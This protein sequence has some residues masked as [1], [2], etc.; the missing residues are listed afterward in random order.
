LRNGP[1]CCGFTV[2]KSSFHRERRG[3]EGLKSHSYRKYIE[4][5]ALCL[6]AIAILWWF[7]RSLNWKEVRYWLGTTNPYL[8]VVAVA[9]ISSAYLVRA[10]RWRVLLRPTGPARLSALFTATTVGFAAVFLLG[11][12]G[13]VVRPVVLPVQ[14]PNV[15][16][17]SSF[18]TIFVERIYDLMAVILMFAFNLLWLKP[19]ST[20]QND[21]PRLRMAGIILLGV[22]FLGVA[23][24]AVFR[25]KSTL[26]IGWIERLFA[27]WQFIPKRVALFVI[28]ILD[29]LSKS[30]RVLVD[31][32]ELV[33]T[34]G[35]TA[36]LWFSVAV[37]NL[38]VI[39]AFGVEFGPVE[40]VFVL[41]WSLVGSLVPTPGGAAG[42]F[43]AATAAALILLGVG[44]EKAAAMSIV[45]HLV[46]FGPALLFGLFYL[47]RGD[48]N[49]SRLR[50]LVSK[51]G[52]TPDENAQNSLR[53]DPLENT[54]G[55]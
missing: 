52:E 6:L 38:L 27:R 55:V 3:K 42:A 11:R 15:R 28:G 21:I 46:D 24:L 4:F 43:H 48:L 13:E 16:P 29:Q 18:V 20:L 33:E 39:R 44:A 53:T 35:L 31:F 36:L 40:T 19:T 49:F 14:D 26:I 23:V 32:K 34:I 1:I 5:A 8:L 25:A 9:I 17:S 41:S 22:A 7:G 37:A 45:L 50:A 2:N 12:A 47:I 10:L 54:A 51:R 30:L